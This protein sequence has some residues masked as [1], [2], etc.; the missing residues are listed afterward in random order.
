[1]PALLFDDSSLDF[2]ILAIRAKDAV[3]IALLASITFAELERFETLLGPEVGVVA[4]L[5]LGF[6]RNVP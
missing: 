1:M 2:L 3:D 4:D 6:E 5:A